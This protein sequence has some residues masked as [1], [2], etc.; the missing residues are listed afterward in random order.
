MRTL[1]LEFSFLFCIF[2]KNCFNDM[3]QYTRNLISELSNIY[4]VDG[5]L[6]E[7]FIKKESEKSAKYKYKVKLREDIYDLT[8]K[9]RGQ[10]MLID[11]DMIKVSE[12]KLNKAD[13]VVVEGMC[14]HKDIS[15]VD[16]SAKMCIT[17]MHILNVTD[18]EELIKYFDGKIKTKA[19]VNKYVDEA[20]TAFRK[21][22]KEYYGFF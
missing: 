4:E 20:W 9:Y 19:E 15:G 12:I 18:I 6:I 2:A 22:L 8:T 7:D 3:N 5:F 17:I 10:Y 13:E 21:K 11:K 14:F 16:V 1:Y